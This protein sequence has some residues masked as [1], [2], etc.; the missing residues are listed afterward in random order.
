MALSSHQKRVLTATFALPLVIAAVIL[1][2]PAEFALL[3][4]V[5][6]MGLWEYYCLFRPGKRAMGLKIAGILFGLGILIASKFGEHRIMIGLFIFAYWAGNLDF[7]YRFG[8]QSK[9][10]PAVSFRNSHVMTTG[11]L[12][13]PLLLQY[14]FQMQSIEICL[15]MLAVIAS[16][17]GAYYAGSLIGGPK[18]WPAVS[19]K[20]TYA[21]SF[22]GMVASVILCLVMGWLDEYHLQGAGMGRPWWM[23][24]LLGMALNVASQL[25]DFFES[26]LKRN[27]NV[28]DSG[29]I[30]PGHGGILD[31][32]DGLLL[33]VPTYAGM[34]ALFD[35]F[36]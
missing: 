36:R 3:A 32:I 24:L 18:I 21:G 31:R 10:E 27:L 9:V 1:R 29:S 35:F 20:K 34:D 8:T 11:L 25:G 4:A 26:A 16:D 14:F 17:T 33:A 7:L 13:I 28:K 15:I 23:W 30:L 19:P 12:Y 2:G 6:S 5:S 22:G